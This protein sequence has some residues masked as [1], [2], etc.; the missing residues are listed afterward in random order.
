MNVPRWGT[1]CRFLVPFPLFLVVFGQKDRRLRRDQR[2][3]ADLFRLMLGSAGVA[4]GFE[5]LFAAN[6]M[7]ALRASFVFGHVAK[8]LIFSLTVESLA[9]ALCGL[10]HLAGFDTRPIVD[11]A[12][13]SRT[14]ADFW[15]RFNARVQS[16]WYLNVFIP[17][18]GRRAPIRGVWA[19]FLAERHPA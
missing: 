18:G 8:L 17:F 4:I 19:T 1:Y 16:W 5:L 15:H 3:V 2:S 11:R 9:Q 6:E 12:F 14:P 13:L 7:T 10:E